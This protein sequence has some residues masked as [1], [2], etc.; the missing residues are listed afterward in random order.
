[1]NDL[2]NY[3]Y[4]GEVEIIEENVKELVFVGD[5]FFIESLKFKGIFFL[6]EILSF[7]N[8]LFVWV[9]LEKFD[10]EELIDKLE[11]FILDNF[12]V[13]LKFEEFLYFSFIEVGNFIFLDDVIVEIEE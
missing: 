10:C 11:S 5:Y 8:C 9:F 6:E 7:L 12:V 2:F 4:I 1:M 3:I 13:V